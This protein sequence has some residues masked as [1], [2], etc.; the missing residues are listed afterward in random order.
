VQIGGSSV[1]IT[2]ASGGLG[3]A[4]ARELAAR[5]AK[6]TL[7]GRRAEV[8]D[9]LAVDLGARVIAADLSDRGEVE[10]LAAETGEL[11]ILIANAG[12][13]AAGRLETFSR[14]QLDRALEVNLHSPIA[15]T[16]AVLPGML[17]RRRGHLVFMSSI[18][19]KTI[20]PGDPLYHATKYGLRGF[21]AALRTDLHGSGVGSSCIFPGFIRGAGIFA[22]ARTKLPPG[23]G[24][25]SPEDVAKAVAQAIEH[26]R[27]EVDVAAFSQ[28]A[29]ARVASLAPDLSAAIVR[30]SGGLRIAR[31]MD[32]ALRDK[33]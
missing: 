15:L 27:G 24:T 5:G 17:E 25:R 1:L 31:E 22:D 13:P 28:R 2:G 19:G 29:G 26:D 18:A 21:A 23:F 12:I 10:G 16:R 3:E 32:E 7:T 8:L 9:A 6:L 4:T 20:V 11:D 33:R 30:R 14:E